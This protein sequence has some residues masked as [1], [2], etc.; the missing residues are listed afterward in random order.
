VPQDWQ[1]Y[2]RQLTQVAANGVFREAQ[3]GADILGDKTAIALQAMQ[4][5]VFSLFGQHC[6]FLQDIA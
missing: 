1:R 5:K 2:R 6:T 4:Q 3:F